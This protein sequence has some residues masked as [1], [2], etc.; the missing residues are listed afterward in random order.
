MCVTVQLPHVLLYPSRGL[1]MTWGGCEIRC[2]TQKK[3]V[4]HK[5]TR[6]QT[7]PAGIKH[8]EKH[9]QRAKKNTVC[10]D[11][12]YVD[13]CV[14]VNVCVF[15]YLFSD[16]AGH[17]F[18]KVPVLTDSVEQLATLHHLHNNQES[19]SVK[20]TNKKGGGGRSEE[21]AKERRW[22]VVQLKKK[23]MQGR[24]LYLGLD[25]CG[26]WTLLA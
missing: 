10:V 2:Y 4:S 6:R 18:S 3:S 7:L 17:L 12:W 26:N 16:L 23:E 14:F 25:S 15:T 20:K 8:P 9:I 21:T 22:I 1:L 24:A 11:S 19:R 13:V 5:E